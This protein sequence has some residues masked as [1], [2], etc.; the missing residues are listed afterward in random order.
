MNLLDLF[1]K[2]SVDDSGVKDGVDRTK[3]KV[4]GS[5]DAISAKSVAIGN[6]IYDVGKKAASTLVDF[7]KF[8]VDAGMAFDASMSNVAAISGAT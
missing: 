8:S 6:A 4:L 1:V 2:I 3:D 7:G 5:A